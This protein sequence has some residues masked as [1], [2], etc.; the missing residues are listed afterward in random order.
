MADVIRLTTKQ[1]RSLISESVQ[2]PM[3]DEVLK[4][5]LATGIL[6]LGLG[7]KPIDVYDTIAI[8]SKQFARE[9]MNTH[10]CDSVADMVINQLMSQF[11]KSTYH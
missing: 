9:Y 8:I 6:D 7:I 10:D 4:R 11:D 2:Y 1:L 5:V 3:R